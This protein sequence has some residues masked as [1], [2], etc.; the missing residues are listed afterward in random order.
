MT[1]R[2]DT[3]DRPQRHNWALVDYFVIGDSGLS[4]DD[5]VKTGCHTV[6]AYRAELQVG[7]QLWIHSSWGGGNDAHLWRCLVFFVYVVRMIDHWC[8]KH[9]LEAVVVLLICM[10]LA[11]ARPWNLQM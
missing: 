11:A 2:P 6:I 4:N 1:V 5:R 10:G 9:L 8:G 7:V 3:V